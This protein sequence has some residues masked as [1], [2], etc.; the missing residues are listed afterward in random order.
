ARRKCR[1]RQGPVAGRRSYPP[2]AISIQT[3]GSAQ[4]REIL[5]QCGNRAFEGG[6]IGCGKLV[7]VLKL[8]FLSA[9]TAKERIHLR[10]IRSNACLK[11]RISCGD[12]GA[13]QIEDL[14]RAVDICLKIRKVGATVAIFLA[15]DLG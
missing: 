11:L 8:P 2:C 15:A 12:Q 6:A 1:P 14:L 5:R 10:E 3:E 4:L 9:I 7:I 13:Q